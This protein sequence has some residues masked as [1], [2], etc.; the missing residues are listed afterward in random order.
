MSLPSVA[1]VIPTRNRVDMLKRCLSRVMPYVADH[2]ECSITVSDDGDAAA[3]RNALAEEIGIVRVIQ[4]PRL[5]PASNRNCGAAHST[6]DLIVFLDDDCIPSVDLIASYQDGALK[7]PEI[8]VFEG[9]ITAEGKIASCADGAPSNETGGYLWSC[10]FAVRREVFAGIGGFDDRFPFAAM[11][12]ND[13]HF[14]VKKCA[15]ILFL[16]E[17]RVWHGVERRLG[18]KLVKH[19]T[20]SVLLYLHIHSPKTA[21]KTPFFF[22]HMAA[23]GLLLTIPRHLRAGTMKHPSF[24]LQRV[25]ANLQLAFILS[26]WRFHA[27]LARC[28]YPP[29]CPGCERIHSILSHPQGATAVLDGKEEAC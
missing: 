29:C 6:G 26:F 4:G 3:T 27:F 12:D 9:R 20:L 22:V 1:I 28:F 19:H 8:G 14:R 15:S 13:F 17:A 11:E 5:G 25:F 23:Q 21:G 2:P 16:P 18:W 10:N 7:N 24:V